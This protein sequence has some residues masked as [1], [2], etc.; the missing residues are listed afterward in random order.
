MGYTTVTDVAN[1]MRTTFDTTTTPTDV[2]VQNYIDDISNEIDE[3]TGTTFTIVTGEVE[4]ITPRVSTNKFITKK[5][6]LLNVTKLEYNDGTEFEPNWIE[7]PDTD[8]RVDGDI[9]ITKKNYDKQVRITYDYG[10]LSVS[11]SVKM[12]ATLMTVKRILGSADISDNEFESV[13]IGP[14]SVASNL[15]MQRIVTL[16]SEIERLKKI[17][18]RYKSILK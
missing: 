9:I 2:E 5:Y 18:G 3:M 4:V 11:S 14:I 6:P 17:V 16:D 7:I 1:Y 12:L 13:S 15:G 8:F 10:H